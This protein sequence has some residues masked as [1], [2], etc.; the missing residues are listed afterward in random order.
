M[1]TPTT[2]SLRTSVP[3]SY[4]DDALNTAESAF[5]STRQLASQVMDRAS[6]KV[7]D[8]R[9]GARDLASKGLS[10]ATDA[11]A[12][13]QKQLSRYADATG[14]YVSQ[15]P[16]KSIVIGVAAGAVIAALVLAARRRNRY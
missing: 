16:V 5:D 15:Q 14:R 8:L 4:A 7:R 10:A 1:N 3:G 9:F 11:T 12:A 13:A 6:D 2:K